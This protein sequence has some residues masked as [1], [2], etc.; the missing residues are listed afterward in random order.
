MNALMPSTRGSFPATSRDLREKYV[1]IP[2]DVAASLPALR[3][4]AVALLISLL[5]KLQYF[6]WFTQ[7]YF[8]LPLNDSFFPSWLQ[9]TEVLIAAYGLTLLGVGLLALGRSKRL[10]V[11]AAAT[12]LIG[13]TVLCVHQQSYND[14]TFFTCWWTTMWCLWFVCR[15]GDDAESLMVRSAF[16]IHVI[17]SMI[18]LG[19]SVG[20]WTPGYWSGEVFYDIYFSSRNYWLFNSLRA[21][22]DEPA[23]QTIS[24]A[25]SRFVIVVEGCGGLI[26]L[27][28]TRWASFLAIGL[29]CNIGLMSNTLLFSVLACLIGLALAALHQPNVVTNDS[30]K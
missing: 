4:V 12:A 20:K 11:W 10:L 19:G 22:F 9:S 28:P 7:I 3:I 6:V 15:L 29:L 5:W 26:W 25:Y 16:L 30:A 21:A 27:L 1:A 24:C 23:L 2:Q 18:L 17:L 14:V 13:L 8:D